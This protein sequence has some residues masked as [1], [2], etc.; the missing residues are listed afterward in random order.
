MLRN[1]LFSILLASAT[2]GQVVM[3]GP[4]MRTIGG[5]STPSGVPTFVSYGGSNAVQTTTLTLTNGTHQAGDILIAVVMDG[6]GQTISGPGGW[7]EIAAQVTDGANLT[8]SAWWFRATG[9][10]ETNPQFTVP[11]NPDIF[12]GA[13]TAWRGCLGTGTPFED[14]TTVAVASTT[15]PQSAAIDTTGID[16]LV[17]VLMGQD[18]NLTPWNGHPTTGWSNAFPTSDTSSSVGADGRIACQYIAQTT[19]GTV[20]AVTIGT[21][22]VAEESASFTFALLPD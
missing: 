6:S 11:V 2:Y 20:A 12:F 9:S 8:V 13:V 1:I 21:L 3:P 19:A 4:I 7:T 5:G 22:N 18:N 15:T 14:P 10:S 16:R 17:V